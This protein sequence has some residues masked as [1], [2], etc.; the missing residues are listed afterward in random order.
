[1]FSYSVIFISVVVVLSNS[2]PCVAVRLL[3]EWCSFIARICCE[4][5]D[6]SPMPPALLTYENCPRTLSDN[7]ECPLMFALPPIILWSPLEQFAFL[8]KTIVCP[9]CSSAW[10]NS[11]LCPSGWR[12]GKRGPRSEPRKLYGFKCIVLLVGRVYKCCKG[13][14]VLGYNPAILRE[15]PVCFIPFRLWHI[16]GFTVECAELIFVLMSAGMSIHGIRDILLKHQ[17]SWFYTQ[18]LKYKQIVN[19]DDK[20]NFPSLEHWRCQFSSCAPS[21]HSISGCFLESFWRK[22]DTYVLCMQKTSLSNDDDSWLSC[23]HTFA[24]ASKSLCIHM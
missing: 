18:K 7:M 1:M 9:K 16:T 10:V 21:V 15:I 22:E 6:E 4:F 24:S 23:D 8:K 20:V 12:D 3:P 5:V 13:H 19:S 2:P 17:A 14:E 11:T